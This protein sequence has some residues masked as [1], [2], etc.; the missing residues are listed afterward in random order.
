MRF[1]TVIPLTLILVLALWG[2]SSEQP[3]APDPAAN[4]EKSADHFQIT[5]TWDPLG[6]VIDWGVWW[7]TPGGITHHRDFIYY[8]YFLGDLA[9]EAISVQ[10][11]HWSASYTG[12]VKLDLTM[13]NANLLGQVGS[14]EGSSS[15]AMIDGAL[16]HTFVL[17]GS[18][19]LAG[20]HIVMSLTGPIDGPYTYVGDVTVDDGQ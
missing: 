10:S 17:Q 11:G 14:L 18:G 15:G 13:E 8:S 6:D 20:Y 2:C 5:G 12:G 7:T 16:D 9:A 19:G 3:L 4:V 1:Q